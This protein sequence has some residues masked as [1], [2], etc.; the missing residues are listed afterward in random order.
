MRWLRTLTAAG[1]LALACLVLSLFLLGWCAVTAPGRERAKQ[2][3]AVEAANAQARA[4]DATARD[5]AADERLTDLKTNTQLEKD[6]INA[7]SPLPDA[8]PSARRLALA[9]ARL[10]HQGA[11][12]ADLP[13]ECRSGG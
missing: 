11:R 8:R 12:D 1:W 13:A 6:L 2:D 4:A 7:V 3:R 9:C 10:R 5:H